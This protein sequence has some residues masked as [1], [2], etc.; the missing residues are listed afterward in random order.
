MM[1]GGDFDA[2]F[3]RISPREALATVSLK[4]DN[5][6]LLEVA[7]EAFEMLGSMPVGLSGSRTGVF[8]DSCI[9]IMYGRTF[10]GWSIWRGIWRTGDA[11]SVLSGRVAYTFGL[12]GPAVTVDTACSSSLVAL[13]LAVQALRSGECALVL[14]GGVTVMATREHLH[15]FTTG[16]ALPGWAV[17]VFAEPPMALVREGVGVLVLERCP[18]RCG[19]AVGCSRWCAVRRSTRTVRRNG[20]AAPNGLAQQRVIRQALADARLSPREVD[21]VEAHGTGTVLGDPIEAQ[22]L[23]RPMAR[24]GPAGSLGLHQVE[25]R[26]FPGRRRAGWCDQDGAGDRHGV[27][28][29]T[30]H[31]DRPPGVGRLVRRAVELLVRRRDWP[32]RA[33]PRRAGVSSFGVSE[34]MP[35]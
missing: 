2:G 6:L 18:R 12:Q 16:R 35:T 11:G 21:A 31:V 23:S 19:M 29:R 3:F 33:R 26:S 9:M 14:A 22:A 27:L 7:W 15:D 34:P 24:T 5:M 17:Q 10:R 28:P 32:E 25:H 4:R 20:L 13:H 30:L 1:T 8:G